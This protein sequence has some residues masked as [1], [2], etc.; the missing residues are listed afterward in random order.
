MI[1]DYLVAACYFHHVRISAKLSLLSSLKSMLF[2][3]FTSSSVR[4]FDETQITVLNAL[5]RL[6]ISHSQYDQAASLLVRTRPNIKEENVSS[7][8]M[9]RYWYYEGVIELFHLHYSNASI[10]LQRALRKVPSTL[11]G[12]S[13]Q[14]FRREC[15][16][17]NTLALLLQGEVP[18]QIL[19]VSSTKPYRDLAIVLIFITNF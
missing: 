4:H 2:A 10:Q 3:T 7:G 13:A 14:W 19:N 18:T 11:S 17:M 12:A 9:A 5:L 1:F 6:F 8:Q 16:V 15:S